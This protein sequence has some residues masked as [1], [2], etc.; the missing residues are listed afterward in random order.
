MRSDTQG[1]SEAL[2]YLLS[3]QQFVFPLEDGPV[4]PGRAQIP[5]LG[6]SPRVAREPLGRQGQGFAV[7]TLSCCYQARAGIFSWERQQMGLKMSILR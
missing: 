1:S 6:A 4:L 2:L 3:P 7:L 5:L